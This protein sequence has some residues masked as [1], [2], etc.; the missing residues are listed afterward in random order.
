MNELHAHGEW[1]SPA[2]ASDARL[3]TME[4]KTWRLPATHGALNSYHL[5]IHGARD[6]HEDV[7]FD[8]ASGS[9]SC[10]ACRRVCVC[11]FT[12]S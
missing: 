11:F 12:F 9:P 3:Q 6:G 7:G 4:K 2:G 1:G 5:Y 10:S 8:V